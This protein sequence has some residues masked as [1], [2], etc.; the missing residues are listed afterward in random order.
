MKISWLI[1]VAKVG[2]SVPCGGSSLVAGVVLGL[3]FGLVVRSGVSK[4]FVYS[5]SVSYPFD[6]DKIEA[7]A[8]VFFISSTN[9]MILSR[10]F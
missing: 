10:S 7:S 1:L 8:L 2:A 6:V 5:S 3:E 9:T 4:G